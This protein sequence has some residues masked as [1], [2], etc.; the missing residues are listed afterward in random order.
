MNGVQVKYDEKFKNNV[1]KL[2]YV[3]PKKISGLCEDLVLEC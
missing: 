1:V 3:S 2:S